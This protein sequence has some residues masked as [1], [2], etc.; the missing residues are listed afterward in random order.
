V[1][2]RRLE[3]A[4]A[5]TTIGLYKAES[6]RD[7]SPFRTGP[8]RTL[9]DPEDVTSAW[10]HWFGQAHATGSAASHRHK[11]RP[12]TTLNNRSGKDTDHS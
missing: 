6:V 1:S 4:L 8:L 3:N 10:V 12:S 9:A 2:G 7:G 5:E 11:P